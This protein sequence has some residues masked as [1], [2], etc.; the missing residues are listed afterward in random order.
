[1]EI[2]PPFRAHPDVLQVHGHLHA[3]MRDWEASVKI[4]TTL[5][6]TTPERTFGWVHLG[7]SLRR[8]GNFPAGIEVLRRGIEVCGKTP[9]LLLNL[10]C[11]HARLG[12]LS[13]AKECLTQALE[14]ATDQD[15][16]HRFLLRAFNE[17]DLMPVWQS[18]PSILV[19]IP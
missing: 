18:D 1:M 6:E 14:F 2:A 11:C 16:K 7:L 5:T 17:S 15:S 8:L 9:T 4:A 12:K 3:Q 10:A 13:E 19:G